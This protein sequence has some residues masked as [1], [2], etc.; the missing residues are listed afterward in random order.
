MAESKYGEPCVQGHSAAI[1]DRGGVNRLQ[2]LFDLA[3]VTWNRERNTVTDATV[4]I[5][6]RAC[7]RQ[8]SVINAI[9]P[10][11]HELVIFRGS[12]RVWEGPIIQTSSLRGSATIIAHDVG[13][14]FQGT[15]LSKAWPNS[16]L[17]G[18]P[19]MT[20]RIREI[21]VYEMLTPYNAEVGT[22]AAPHTVRMER[23]ETIDPPINV[24]PYL[25][26]M[27]GTVKT[28]SATV[29]FEMKLMEHLKNLAQSGVDFATVGRKFLVW[30][31]HHALSRTRQVTEA[32]FQG[33]IE[34][35][36]SGSDYAAIYHVS[37]TR[38][39]ENPAA[40]VGN[41]GAPDPYY[42]VWTQL[43]SSESEQ[44]E[45]TLTQWALNTQ[46][47]VSLVGRYGTVPLELR[48]P[49]S[50]GI[51]LSHDLTIEELMPG[52]EMPVLATLNLRKVSQMQLITKVEVKETPEGENVSLTLVPS[53][54]AIAVPH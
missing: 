38:D 31:T 17:G 8:Q 16:D 44:G 39:E 35:I 11:R 42:G 9:E 54:E 32:D 25:D 5:N 10:E 43:R 2:P 36:A 50:A 28:R 6:G 30:D 47:H 26:V 45:N 15:V 18:P 23:W 41:A 21:I 49:G 20:D 3:E 27:D 48:M 22:E 7:E 12:T 29:P 34:V 19:L 37:A 52:V 13:E 33:D 46:A 24:L 53:A 51:Q 14:Y 40:G 4:I 1:Y